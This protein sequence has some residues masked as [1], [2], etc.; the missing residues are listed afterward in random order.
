MMK[1]LWVKIR[2]ERALSNYCHRQNKISLGKSISYQSNRTS[3]EKYEQILKIAPHPCLLHS[4][5]FPLD[6]S[7]SFLQAAVGR[8]L[9]IAVSSSHISAAPFFSCS[10]PV[11]IWSLSHVRQSFTAFSNV[12]SSHGLQFFCNCSGVC[13]FHGVQSFRNSQLQCGSLT[14]KVVLPG[15]LPE[16][17]LLSMGPQ[18]LPEASSYASFP[19]GNTSLQDAA[20]FSVESFMVSSRD[21][22]PWAAGNSALVPGPV[23]LLLLH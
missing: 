5:K 19:W 12:S 4:L 20:C 17:G 16:H 21:L 13:S 8:G 11:P 15:N 2:T 23:P 3:Y 18:V 1:C 7:T 22:L 10:C 9:A 14:G 6:F